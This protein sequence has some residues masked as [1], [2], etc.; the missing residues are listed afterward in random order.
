[1]IQSI[2]IIGTDMATTV[3]FGVGFYTLIGV[4]LVVLFVLTIKT[5]QDKNFKTLYNIC[6]DI[7]FICVAFLT[8][9]MIMFTIVYLILLVYI[10]LGLVDPTEYFNL[11]GP[12]Y[13]NPDSDPLNSYPEYRNVNNIQEMFNVK[14]YLLSVKQELQDRLVFRTPQI[15]AD[16]LQGLERIKRIPNPWC[17]TRQAADLEAHIEDAR[18]NLHYYTQH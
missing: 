2:K 16:Q 9:L 14:Q 11:C 4:T 17:S 13:M 8:L 6:K 7:V 1:M 5:V 18:K 15:Y 10:K 3:P 12:L